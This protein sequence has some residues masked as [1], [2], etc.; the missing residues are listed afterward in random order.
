MLIVAISDTHNK[1]NQIT[2]P[3]CDLLIHAGD[4]TGQGTSSEV[5]NFAKWFVKQPAKHKI[6]VPGNH[7]KH[8][9]SSLPGSMLWF[10]EH[11]PEAHVLI[12]QEVTIEGLKIYGSPV[13]P[14]FH[15]WAWN[16]HV[17]DIKKH[18]E[19]I[20]N[21]L[22]ILITHGPPHGILD[23]IASGMEHLGC[24]ELVKAIEQKTPK[25]HIFGH[26]HG[27]HGQAYSSNTSFYNVSMLNE[28]YVPAHIPTLI[29]VD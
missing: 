2:I 25:R 23:Q 12:D 21:N 22:D 6:W 26:I 17:E 19:A 15:N 13:T 27:G 7:E 18:W 16:R 11:C 20:P 1:H 9:E 3:E 5:K 10:T 29:R 4:A 8:F 24:K 28:A 14:W